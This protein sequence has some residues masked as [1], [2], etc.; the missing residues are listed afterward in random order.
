MCVCV[1]VCVCVCDDD[2]TRR[3]GR[4]AIPDINVRYLTLGVRYISMTIKIIQSAKSIELGNHGNNNN[5]VKTIFDANTEGSK[6]ILVFV[7]LFGTTVVS[8][9]TQSYNLLKLLNLV[10]MA[11]SIF[12]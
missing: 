12:V 7:K 3:E 9:A 4:A 10:T 1:C 2:E 6:K 8:M 5:S 11:T